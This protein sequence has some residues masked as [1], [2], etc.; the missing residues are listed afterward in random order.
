[1]NR[2]SNQPRYVGNTLVSD[3]PPSI[4]K[5]SMVSS[6]AADRRQANTSTYHRVTYA[7]SVEQSFA[8]DEPNVFA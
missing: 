8:Y 7:P 3:N 4:S 2:D 1:M 6:G 5:S